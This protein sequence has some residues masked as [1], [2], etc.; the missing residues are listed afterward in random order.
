MGRSERRKIHAR[1]AHVGREIDR[2]NGHIADAR[3][4]H[5]TR[6]ELRECALQL[7]LDL[8]VARPRCSQKL[9]AAYATL[10]QRTGDLDA[11]EALDLIVDTHVLVVLDANAALNRKS[12]RLN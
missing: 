12:T 3:I 7:G 2:G 11:R 6:D 8:A 5:L 10:L 1:H 9:S 4:L